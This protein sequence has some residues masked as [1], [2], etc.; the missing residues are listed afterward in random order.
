MSIRKILIIPIFALLIS[1]TNCTKSTPLTK[2][3][4]KYAGQWQ[5]DDGSY[6]VIE[7]SG[8]GDVKRS[9]MTIT[10]GNTT[11]D[12]STI[13]IGMMGI[14]QTYTITKEPITDSIHGITT[15]ELDG[16]KY[17]KI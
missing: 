14:E 8:K 16:V 2:Q 7:Y 11:I 10:G 3:Q 17:I 15:M 4:H 13:V 5:C 12:S 6:F 1:L 9:G